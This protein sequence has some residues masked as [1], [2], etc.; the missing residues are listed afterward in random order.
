MAPSY[1]RRPPE[2]ASVVGVD[3]GLSDW[4]RARLRE[5]DAQR[6]PPLD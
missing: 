4:E 1:R 6:P 5:L 2:L 3:Y